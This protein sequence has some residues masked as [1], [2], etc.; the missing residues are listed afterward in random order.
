MR[1]DQ[2]DWKKLRKERIPIFVAGKNNIGRFSVNIGFIENIR[3]GSFIKM[4]RKGKST[5]VRKDLV[6]QMSSMSTFPFSE[7]RVLIAG[8]RIL[9][10]KNVRIVENLPIREKLIILSIMKSLIGSLVEIEILVNNKK[11]IR[12][13]IVQGKVEDLLFLEYIEISDGLYFAFFDE[14]FIVQISLLQPQRIPIYSLRNLLEIDPKANF[15][16]Q[17]LQVLKEIVIR[18]PK[19]VVSSSFKLDRELERRR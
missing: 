12:K 17:M 13:E 5:Q 1:L 6:V 18:N 19:L 7:I 9:F 16:S 14:T 10:R 15:T 2:I 4:K 11:G 3:E 8:E